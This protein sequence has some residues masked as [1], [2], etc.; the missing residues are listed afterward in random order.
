MVSA[1]QSLFCYHQPCQSFR[2]V[3]DVMFAS[4]D[5]ES[6]ELLVDREQVIRKAGMRW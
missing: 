6:N 1:I 2:I 5:F 4:I 3:S